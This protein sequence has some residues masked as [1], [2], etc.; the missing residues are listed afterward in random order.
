MALMFLMIAR[1]PDGGLP[2]FDAYE[3]AVLPLLAEH[4][5][6]LERRLRATDDGLEAHVVTFPGQAAFDAYRADSRR[7]AA[8]PLLEASAA[9]IE[10]HEVEDVAAL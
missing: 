7:A 10:L 3:S 4:G 9:M 8:T 5:G 2:D 6:R 1:I